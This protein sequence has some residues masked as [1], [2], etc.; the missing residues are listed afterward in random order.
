VSELSP[1][2]IDTS[3]IRS[4]RD[5]MTPEERE[6]IRA[7]MLEASNA[8]GTFVREHG[9]ARDEWREMFGDMSNASQ[10]DAA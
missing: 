8:L 5:P 6:A 4:P 1:P 2:R 7:D 10:H 3:H 9:D